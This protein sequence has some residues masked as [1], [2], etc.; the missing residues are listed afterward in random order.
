MVSGEWRVVWDSTIRH[1]AIRYSLA[2]APTVGSENGVIEFDVKAAEFEN[3]R[4][5]FVHGAAVVLLGE[6]LFQFVQ[7]LA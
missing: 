7:S 4:D 1:F 5:G 6:V 2:L 3:A